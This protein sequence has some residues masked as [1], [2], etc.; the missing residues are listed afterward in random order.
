[1]VGRADIERIPEK[2][3]DV[4]KYLADKAGMRQA[5]ISDMEHGKRELRI[6]EYYRICEELNVDYD[7]LT[8][9]LGRRIR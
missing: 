4:A 7:F 2:C 1:M 6:W 3:A 9:E 8:K 5:A